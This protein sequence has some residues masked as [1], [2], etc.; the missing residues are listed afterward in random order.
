LVTLVG[1]AALATIAAI[2]AKADDSPAPLAVQPPLPARRS[3]LEDLGVDLTQKA[4]EGRLPPIVGR[5]D[6]ML[7]V[8]R[9]LSRATKNAPLLIGASG[10]GKTAIVEGLAAQI[11]EGNV[12]DAIRD[13]RLVQINLADLVAG[14]SLRGEF[15][16]RLQA[17]VRDLEAA[18]DVILFIDEIHTLIGAGKGS[19]AMDAANI[20]KPALARGAFRCIGATTT[21]EYHAYIERDPA[22]ERRFQPIVVNEPG[23]AETEEMLRHNL[24]RLEA[25]HQVQ[26]DAE[27]I[28]AAVE[29]SAKY[30]PDRRLPDKALDLLDEACARSRITALSVSL[31]ERDTPRRSVTARAVAEVLAEWT[32]IP[33]G[34]LTEDERSRLL[35]MPALLKQRVI[36]QD[37]AV[38][39]VALAVQRARTG[40]K[41]SGR[42]IAVLLFIGP[43][44][45][46]KTELARVTAE[47]LF[48]SEQAMTRLDM[49]EYMEA[50]A[51]SRLIGAPPGYVGYEDEGQLT[52]ALRRRSFGLV[53]FDEVE[54]AHPD[55]HNLFLQLFDD[56]RLTDAR[57][58]VVDASN[59]LFIMTSN[60]S[61][62]RPVGLRSSDPGAG[63]RTA[64]IAQ[65]K[66]TFRPEL[67]NRIDEVVVFDPLRPDSLARITR[68]MLNSL[69]ERLA[70]QGLQLRA[71]DAAI[72]LLVRQGSVPE[73]GARPLRGVISRLVENP[74]GGMLLRGEARPGQTIVVD[75]QHNEIILGVETR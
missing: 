72:A 21:D 14:T 31:Q 2:L 56:G 22:L 25:R 27:A 1:E 61:V 4:R 60:V 64:V 74:L 20:L 58:R 63:D 68:L 17:L 52:G 8:V 32:G 67:L 70:G 6:E 38:D 46:G 11:A 13:Q 12:P 29:L 69:G 42:P 30:I 10:V 54:K 15:E 35:Q 19:G 28:R 41:P 75:E 59:T 9:T 50:H 40:L 26:I 65:L 73:Y 45:V 3:I 49:S 48:G 55:V 24:P 47:F 37:A 43:T 33:A 44:G 62:N 16:G 66:S 18:T 23:L 36:G 7:Q 53:L 5:K 51:V 39:A 71:S 57:G 34:Q